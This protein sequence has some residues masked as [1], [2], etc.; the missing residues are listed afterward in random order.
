MRD[1]IWI[2][3]LTFLLQ[4]LKKKKIFSHTLFKTPDCDSVK[5]REAL[6]SGGAG[7]RGSVPVKKKK[8][9]GGRGENS[10]KVVAR[11]RPI[12]S[13]KVMSTGA[14]VRKGRR[15][16]VSETSSEDSDGDS[17]GEDCAGTSRKKKTK[18]IPKT[19]G[20]TM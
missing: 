19:K 17:T 6:R 10:E 13:R 12:A 9:G 4:L 8:T 20:K 15:V 7:Q 1:K 11:T 2:R 14:A 16:T 18:A 3:Y 5:M